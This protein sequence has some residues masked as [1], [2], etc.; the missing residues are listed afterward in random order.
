MNLERRGRIAV[1]RPEQAIMAPVGEDGVV[2]QDDMLTYLACEDAFRLA[3]DEAAAIVDDARQVYEAERQAGYAQG[4]ADGRREMAAAMAAYRAACVAGAEAKAAGLMALVA[5]AVGRVVGSTP[6]QERVAAAVRRAL[7]D[8]AEGCRVEIHL[9]PDNAAAVA[10]ML[11]EVAA[12]ATFRI[13]EAP[14]LGLSAARLVSETAVIVL[15]GDDLL[16]SLQRL[17]CD[18]PA[19]AAANDEGTSP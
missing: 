18:A 11:S 16:A 1:L 13:V 8:F 15:D 19:S 5:A 14:L 3:R 9:H 2:R 17:I 6:P 7:D 10:G 12:A 4:L